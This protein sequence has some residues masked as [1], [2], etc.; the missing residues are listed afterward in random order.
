MIW[1]ATNFSVKMIWGMPDAV[2][3]SDADG[4]FASGMRAQPAYSALASPRL[5]VKR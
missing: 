3:Y 5:L 1:D 4:R 2:I